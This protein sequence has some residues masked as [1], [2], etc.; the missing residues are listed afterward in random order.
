MNQDIVNVLINLLKELNISKVE[1]S[2][3][4][5]LNRGMIADVLNRKKPLSFISYVTIMNSLNI[6]IERYLQEYL[7]GTLAVTKHPLK[8]TTNILKKCI[9]ISRMDIALQALSYHLEYS[10]NNSIEERV[11]NMAEELYKDAK[12]EGAEALYVFISNSLIENTNLDK[13]ILAISYY[14]L[15]KIKQTKNL[16]NEDHALLTRM[17]LVHLPRNMRLNALYNLCLFYLLEAY[18]WVIL[19]Y[20][21][22]QMIELVVEIIEAQKIIYLSDEK[23]EDL[24]HHLVRYYGQGYLMQSSSFRNRGIYQKAFELIDYYSDLSWFPNLNTEGQEHVQRFKIYAEANTY[25]LQLLNG[26]LDVIPQYMEYLNQNENEMLPSIVMILEA[27]NRH[28]QIIDDNIF[29]KAVELIILRD[30]LV[31]HH[32]YYEEHKQKNEY[33]KLIYQLSKYLF[34]IGN[35]QLG[36]DMALRFLETAIVYKDDKMILHAL[37]LLETNKYNAAN[38]QLQSYEKIREGVTYYEEVS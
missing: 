4:C 32:P 36:I 30:N 29:N 37:A 31:N 11:F 12:Y 33:I 23:D 25:N 21:T 1:F 28:N 3:L 24:L 6:P 26:N 22:K 19:E 17:N 8:V 35:L 9:E 34:R 2:K 16:K 14:R 13:T 20:L 18:D 10:V 5:G 38:S 7:L 15:F 27:I